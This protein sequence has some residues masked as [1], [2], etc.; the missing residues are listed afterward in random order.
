MRH[1]LPARLQALDEP[2]LLWFAGRDIVPPDA[3][4]IRPARD[5]FEV[6]FV[7]L[8]LTIAS[9]RRPRWRI[10]SPSSRA[11]RRPEIEVSATSARH[12]RVE[13]LD[14][15]LVDGMVFPPQQHVQA[16]IT[17]P[18]SLLGERFQPLA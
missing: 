10:I 2:V 3:G 7:P 17:K 14:P 16:T 12:S 15:L 11:T 5:A 1:E 9:G 13:A 4:F 6:S 8:S 18:P